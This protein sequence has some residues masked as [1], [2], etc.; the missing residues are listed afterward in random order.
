[1]TES[2]ERVEIARRSVSTPRDRCAPLGWY[3]GRSSINTLRLLMEVGGLLYLCDST[4]T[5]C[6]TGSGARLEAASGHSLYARCNDM[7]FV[8]H[9]ALARG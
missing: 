7:R 2:E 9:R 4:P 6:H 5:T 8:N 3:T 1:M